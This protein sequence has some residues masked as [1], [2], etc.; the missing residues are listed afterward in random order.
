MSEYKSKNIQI[1][2][3]GLNYFNRHEFRSEVIIEF[4]KPYEVPSELAEK[5]KINKRPATEL[6]LAE[7][8]SRMKAVTMTAPSFTEL[9]SLLLV[10]KLYLP[11]DLRLSPENYSLMCQRFAKGYE[12]LK[13][14][15]ETRSLMTKIH[16]YIRELETTGISDHEVRRIEFSLKWMFKK[17]ILNFILFHVFLI[18]SLPGFII[19]F[20]IAFYLSKKVEKERVAAKA[21]NPNKIEALDVVSS[22]KF[23]Y[24]VLCAPIIISIWLIL[25]LYYYK[26]KIYW[27]PIDL[28]DFSILIFSL[29]FLPFYVYCIY[30]LT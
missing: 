2:P 5:F 17:L 23:Q 1:V 9:R 24:A 30:N 20:P 12:K 13:E 29:L 11:P 21:K 26:S 27:L 4:G 28:S 3:V 10:R 7:I 16:K 22:I 6:L 18:L 14:K 19:V 8:H 15:E 25:S